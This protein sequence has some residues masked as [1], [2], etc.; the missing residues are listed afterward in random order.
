MDRNLFD[1]GSTKRLF[2]FTEFKKNCE[3]VEHPE[4]NLRHR[5]TRNEQA[6]SIKE[7]ELSEPLRDS[8]STCYEAESKYMYSYQGVQ[9]SG[10]NSALQSVH[11]NYSNIIQ[12]LISAVSDRFDGIIKSS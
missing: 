8:I 7:I 3:I 6:E 2:Q 12:K 1:T 5:V 10:F 9:L 11:S 4:E